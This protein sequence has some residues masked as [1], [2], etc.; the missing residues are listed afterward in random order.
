MLHSYA[1][2]PFL[3]S[4]LGPPPPHDVMV[5]KG[6]VPVI[7]VVVCGLTS[8]SFQG[9]SGQGAGKSVLCNRFI[10]PNQDDLRLQH[11]S[12]LNLSEFGSNVINNTH[13]LYWGEKSAG[14]DDGQTVKFQV[15]GNRNAPSKLILVTAVKINVY[16]HDYI[17]LAKI[18]TVSIL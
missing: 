4:Q 1:H 2:P 18:H 8:S 17:K 5:G 11:N 3:P 13:F 7:H 14:M 10:R 9:L 6:K 16:L 15:R 12:V